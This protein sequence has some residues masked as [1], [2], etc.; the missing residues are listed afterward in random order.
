MLHTVEKVTG[1]ILWAN[2]HLLFW[3]SLIPF[4]TAWM[5]ENHFASMPVAFYGGVLFMAGVA[6]FILQGLIIGSHG[7]DSVLKKAVGKDIKGKASLILYGVA[8]ICSV[9]FQWVS[10]GLYSF[11]AFIWIIPDKRIEKVLHT[12]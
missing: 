2:L 1:A 4:T 6:Y 12:Q 8:I 11:V 9:Y 10:L 7:K 5:G 3:L